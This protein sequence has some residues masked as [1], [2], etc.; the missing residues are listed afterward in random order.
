MQEPIFRHVKKIVSKLASDDIFIIGKGPSLDETNLATLPPGLVINLNDSE[1]VRPGDIGIFSANWVRHSLA[2][3]G[4]SC[5]YYLAGKPLPASVP[6]ELLPP[7]PLELDHDDFTIAR[8]ERPEFFDEPF[9]LLNALKLSLYLA[10]LRGRPQRVYLLG[11]D[12]ST[13][14]GA[15]SQKIGTDFSGAEAEERD[16]VITSQESEFRQ[17]RRYFS[18]GSRLILRHI[19]HKDY[20]AF[21]CADFNC[22]IAGGGTPHRPGRPIDLANPDRVLVVAEFTNN[23]L[24]EAARLVEMIERATEA[25]ADLIKVQKRHVDSFYSPENLASYY[26]SPFGETLGDYRRGVELN[27]ELLALLDSTCRKL[28]IQWFCSV[29]D[30]PSYEAILRFEPKLIKIPSTISNHRDYH[31]RLALSYHGPIVVSTGL[32]EQEYIDH[33]LNTYA[34]NEVIYLLHCISAYPAP[35]A[36]CNIAVVRA[37]EALAGRDPRIIPGYSSHDLGSTGCSL[38]I[39]A[40]ARMLE[41][42]VKLGDVDWIH[43]DKVAIDLKTKEFSRFVQDVR[44]AEEIVGSKEKRILDSEHHKYASVTSHR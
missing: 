40:G 43:F 27:D 17:F 3:D 15:V 11:F 32:T 42:H 34:H 30:Y 19:G 1:R 4:F 24:G 18:D 31:A 22:E 5:L 23:H 38:A 35:R 20:S 7:V 9:V 37:Y 2:A 28:G 41:K 12:F 21:T 29:L 8:L 36:D 10:K 39:A 14:G 25:G 33:V 13:R 44:T 6:H 26:W 16:A